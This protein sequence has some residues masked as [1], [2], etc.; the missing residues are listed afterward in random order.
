MLDK[1][2]PTTEIITAI[3]AAIPGLPASEIRD[4]IEAICEHHNEAQS[5][6]IR[7]EEELYRLRG[8]HRRLISDYYASEQADTEFRQYT[9]LLSQ[10]QYPS[11]IYTTSN[12]VGLSLPLANIET[13]YIS[14]APVPSYSEDF[15]HLSK[16]QA[17]KVIHK[18]DLLGVRIWDQG[19]YRLVADPFAGDKLSLSFS[20]S[21][22]F[23]Y[24]FTA[25]LLEDEVFESLISNEGN[26]IDIL[27][28]RA[29]TLPLRHILLPKISCLSNLN[30][31]ISA[32]GLACVVAMA[33]GTPHNDYCIPLQLRSQAVAEGRGVYTT[34]IQAW[35]QPSVDNYQD[36]VQLY[37]TVLRELFEEAFGGKEAE[38]ESQRLRYDW[39]LSEC[40]GV[41]YIHE[42]P[43][44]VT[45]EF[46]GIGMN[47][48]LGTYDCAIL[49][50]I[51][52][53]KY[54]DT[55]SYALMRNWE[56]QSMKLLSTRKASSF[57]EKVFT[58]GWFDQ[59]MFSLSQGLL[60]LRQLDP[61]HVALPDI[62]IEL[63]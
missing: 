30:N 8:M 31:R 21:N 18:F 56:T 59:G 25:G 26:I 19:L 41:A 57:L 15:V 43:D 1:F 10:G 38:Q 51:H 14:T 24:R 13:N 35:H 11:T 2:S 52:D 55:Y 9:I 46:L 54:W 45:L 62:G 6:K 17:A 7:E 27:Q 48:L 33:R 53:P 28:N 39:Y 3:A 23:P 47:A 37:W 22:Y 58:S 49:L 44:A 34:S 32:G 4:A 40:P 50:A 61:K 42:N 60:R 16:K 5:K 29:S 36:E 12:R 20:L 63:D